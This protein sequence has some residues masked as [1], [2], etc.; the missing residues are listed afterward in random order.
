MDL[1]R[2]ALAPYAKTVEQFNSSTAHMAIVTVKNKYQVVIPQSVRDQVGVNVGDLFEAKV[3][4]GKI[5]LTPKSLVDR[6]IAEGL[7]DVRK[8][9]VR[10]PFSTVDEMLDSLKGRKG[11]HAGRKARPR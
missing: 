7:E 2:F 1:T 4:K 9:R 6:A 10:G 3:E 5:T 11:S 8:G